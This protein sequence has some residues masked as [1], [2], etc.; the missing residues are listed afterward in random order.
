M[1]CNFN[2]LKKTNKMRIFIRKI[3]MRLMYFGSREPACYCD[4]MRNCEKCDN[5]I[6][7][8]NLYFFIRKKRFFEKINF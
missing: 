6:Y 2:N 5:P 7:N 1:I 3:M 8:F 4:D